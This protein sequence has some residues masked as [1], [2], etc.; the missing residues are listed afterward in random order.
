MLIAVI[1][2]PA[3]PAWAAL[4][5]VWAI[6]RNRCIKVHALVENLPF[7]NIGNEALTIE[8]SG[9]V[10]RA[11]RRGIVQRIDLEQPVR[12]VRSCDR[13]LYQGGALPQV[14]RG[15]FALD[16]PCLMPITQVCRYEDASGIF[17]RQRY[18][19]D[20]A[21]SVLVPKD[22]GIAKVGK[23]QI[24]HRISCKPLPACAIV[25]A[26]RQP[27]R[28]TRLLSA[29]RGGMDGDH[30]I[31]AKAA[32]IRSV[33]YRAA[34]KDHVAF[35]FKQGW[36]MFVPA[37]QIRAGGMTP[38][39]V[40][41]VLP[42][43]IA[44]E[45][46]MPFLPIM[47]QAIRVAQPVCPGAKMVGWTQWEIRSG[48]YGFKRRSRPIISRTLCLQSIAKNLVNFCRFSITVARWANR[49]RIIPPRKQ[50]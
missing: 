4:R 41:P 38:G 27:L 40:P 5:V 16:P 50:L 12:P 43:R 45:E 26:Y 19:H 15:R 23:A 11:G 30:R 10:E 46:Q 24:K 14:P 21:A 39:H 34:R 33:N 48:I 31:A 18:H 3:D 17:D 47:D 13:K 44:L 42:M 20:P 28:L 49:S 2:H 37:R 22:A 1:A 7:R 36:R 35:V 6:P 8:S 29:H 32:G 9:L 25:P